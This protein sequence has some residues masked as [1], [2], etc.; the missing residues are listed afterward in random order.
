MGRPR[1]QRRRHHYHVGII[2]AVTTDATYVLGLSDAPAQFKGDKD[3]TSDFIADQERDIAAEYRDTVKQNN[4]QLPQDRTERLQ[5]QSDF[6]I[7]AM[8][9]RNPWMKFEVTPGR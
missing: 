6:T 8:I 7:Q 9:I 4:V 1:G 3:Y 2:R 5:L